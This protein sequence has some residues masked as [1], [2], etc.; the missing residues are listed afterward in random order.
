MASAAAVSRRM[1]SSLA[2]QTRACALFRGGQRCATCPEAATDRCPIKD[3]EDVPA[4][5]LA[6]SR[7][8]G[9]TAA[10]VALQPHGGIALRSS[11]FNRKVPLSAM[12]APAAARRAVEIAAENA[13]WNERKTARVSAAVAQP[14]DS[15]SVSLS[16][17]TGRRMFTDALAANSLNAYFSLSEQMV[18]QPVESMRP[19]TCLSVVLNA[20]G[21]DPHKTWR[22]IWRWNTEEVLLGKEVGARG[23]TAAAIQ[24]QGGLKLYELAE[25]A[26]NNGA[27]AQAFPAC[28]VM[29]AGVLSLLS[30]TSGEAAFRSRVTAQCSG[31]ETEEHLVVHMLSQAGRWKYAP[32]GGYHAVTDCVLVLDLDRS[33]APRWVPLKG[34][35]SSMCASNEGRM[36]GFVAISSMVSEPAA[37]AAPDVAGCPRLVRSWGLGKLVVAPAWE[38][39]VAEVS[40]VQ[41]SEDSGVCPLSI[42]AAARR[43]QSVSR[44]SQR[45]SR[46]AMRLGSSSMIKSRS[47]SSKNTA[48]TPIDEAIALAGLLLQAWPLA[49]VQG[50]TRVISRGRSVHSLRVN[51]V[52]APSDDV[53]VS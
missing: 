1:P 30:L 47:R 14:T 39:T 51:A 28:S 33:A 10:T 29:S 17:K 41:V 31:S 15:K 34:L 35:W 45:L 20:L 46:N 49:G 44:H 16:S 21:H 11:S 5:L 9:A 36:G 6:R 43:N 38:A 13:L 25:L 18:F 24:S 50:P 8:V 52:P 22:P 53:P 7:L 26:R 2:T 12:H 48:D 42:W 37:L 32:V 3:I 27:R 40:E 4:H 19:V 23:L